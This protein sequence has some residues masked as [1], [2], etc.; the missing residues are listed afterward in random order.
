MKMEGI[1]GKHGLRESNVWFCLCLF[2]YMTDCRW[3]KGWRKRR[4]WSEGIKLYSKDLRGSR[5]ELGFHLEKR[6]IQTKREKKGNIV[7]R[8][9][10]I[11][12]PFF[13]PWQTFQDNKGKGN[14]VIFNPLLSSLSLLFVFRVCFLFPFKF[15]VAMSVSGLSCKIE[16]LVSAASSYWEGFCPSIGS[17]SGSPVHP[18][19]KTEIYP[20]NLTWNSFRDSWFYFSHRTTRL[21][22]DAPSL[23]LL[24]LRMYCFCRIFFSRSLRVKNSSLV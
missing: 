19:P 8:D 6:E 3:Q 18:Y 13:I 21:E 22:K 24:R 9:Q 12:H 2:L 14:E 10:M 20:W 7:I 17:P 23:V 1:K 4:K 11:C 5:N 16:C 15:L